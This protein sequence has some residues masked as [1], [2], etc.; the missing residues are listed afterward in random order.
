MKMKTI[1]QI[2]FSVCLLF[3]L[4]IRTVNAQSKYVVISTFDIKTDFSIPSDFPIK[5]NTGDSVLDDINFSDALTIWNQNSM[6]IS[7]ITLP[8]PKDPTVAKIYFEIGIADFNQFSN[9]RK[10]AIEA[11]PELYIIIR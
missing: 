5:I 4:G 1:A 7:K 3:L 11:D 2:V 10:N 9:E 8:I 6:V